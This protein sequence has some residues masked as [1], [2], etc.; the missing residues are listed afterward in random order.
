MKHASINLANETPRDALAWELT[1]TATDDLAVEN[2]VESLENSAGNLKRILDI[3]R[4][5]GK[6]CS[7]SVKADSIWVEGDDDLVDQL[8]NQNL[9]EFVDEDEPD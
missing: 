1:Q 9:A 2:V 5:S 6:D 3:V 7:F 4:P 8:V